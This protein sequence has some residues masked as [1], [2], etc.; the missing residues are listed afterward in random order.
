M[1]KNGSVKVENLLEI[2]TYSTL[3]QITSSVS[4][5]LQTLDFLKIFKALFPC[6]SIT[7]AP[8]ME[9]MK[10]IKNLEEDERGVYCGAI[11]Y[12]SP[13]GK[14][15]FSVP[16]RILQKE[17]KN[18][19]IYKVGGGIVWDSKAKNEWQ[20]T[21]IKTQFLKKNSAKKFSLIETMLFENK[22]ISFKKEHLDRLMKSASFFGFKIDRKL[23]EAAIDN[24]TGKLILEDIKKSILRLEINKKGKFYIDKINFSEDTKKVRN[25]R[26]SDIILDKTNF[27]L[28][29]KTTY[30]PWY[31]KTK[32]LIE[33]KEIFDE[34]FINQDSEFCE[35]SRTNIFVEING[36][37]FTPPLSAGLLN[38]ILRQNLINQ[39]KC[40][41][42]KLYLK[43]L[44]NA[45]NI[46]L[47]N[48]V[49]GLVRVVVFQ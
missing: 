45:K 34:I 8:K 38:G 42:K 37:L 44:K 14:S 17:K 20:E 18:K 40:K 3:H 48:S 27:F 36:K 13:A 1:A 7:G 46:Y 9:T 2:E 16:I 30:R 33:K 15:V 19:W 22:K 31:S 10:I 24:L 47:G 21:K 25:I 35:G 26:I 11:G 6:G 29:H 32:S 4:A 43:D 49:R 41:V 23:I 28:K 39:G 12:I 5:E